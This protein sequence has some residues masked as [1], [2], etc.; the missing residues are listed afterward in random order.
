VCD[1]C[2]AVC[3]NEAIHFI[4][5]RGGTRLAQIDAALCKECGDCTTICPGDA[6]A[7]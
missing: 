6:F 3:P 1:N 7:A 4:I 2:I 5:T